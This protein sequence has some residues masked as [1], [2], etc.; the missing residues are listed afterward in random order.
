MPQ[1]INADLDAALAFVKRRIEEQGHRSG[2]PLDDEERLL[3]NNLPTTSPIIH[4]PDPEFPVPIPRDFAFEK[5]C[6]LANAAYACD[7]QVNRET[8]VDWK[9]AIAVLKLEKHPMYWLLGWGGIVA[10]RPWWDRLLLWVA[11]VMF[12]IC[13]LGLI[14]FADT[15]EPSSTVRVSAAVITCYV[16]V[17]TVLYFAFR[18]F[19]DWQLRSDVEKYR[20]TTGIYLSR[21]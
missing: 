5:L 18:R 21:G 11:G 13:L 9:F 3:L 6:K 20:K 15:R 17:L 7:L 1:L 8:E 19:E 12:V 2:N 14:F 10:K 4:Y 16:A